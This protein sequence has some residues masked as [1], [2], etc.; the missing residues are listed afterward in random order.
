MST[1]DPGVLRAEGYLYGSLHQAFPVL[2]AIVILVSLD[3]P[4]T[5]IGWLVGWALLVLAAAWAGLT[6]L[7]T[8]LRDLALLPPSRWDV[9]FRS[10]RRRT[11]LVAWLLLSVAAAGVSGLF[12]PADALLLGSS[13]A[14]LGG[15]LALP[16]LLVGVR[17]VDSLPATRRRTGLAVVVAI[18][19]ALISLWAI[20]TSDRAVLQLRFSATFWSGFMAAFLV[21]FGS[22]FI[23]VIAT[24]RALERARADD[25]RLA[26]AEE[27][28]RFARDLHDVFGRTLSAVALRS[29]L[30]AAQAERGRPEAANTMREVQAIAVDALGEVRDVVR[31]YREADLTS[32]VAGARSLLEAAGSAVTTTHE[33]AALLPAPVARAFAWTVREAATNI[34][35]HADAR[36]VRIAVTATDRLAR[37]EVVNDRPHPPSEEPGSGLA[38]LAERLS[39]VGGT[40]AWK[41][42]GDAFALTATVDAPALARLRT[43]LNEET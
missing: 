41:H 37:L 2:P 28:V 15:V 11:F 43:V 40:L 20:P 19:L 10:R 32:E 25:A 13:C 17:T 31:G 26:V 36:T 30:A 18:A 23:N 3:G 7:H 33:G 8:R 21:S 22:M 39:E 24:T 29:E 12:A 27:R 4:T 42:R 9:L 1:I 5:P 34:L 38:G 35:R 14:I 16:A 6:V